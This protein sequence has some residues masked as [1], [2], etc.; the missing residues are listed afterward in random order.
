MQFLLLCDCTFQ[1]RQYSK[2]HR[3]ERQHVIVHVDTDQEDCAKLLDRYDQ[4]TL[5]VVDDDRRVLGV[6][7]VDDLIDVMQEEADEDIAHL[8]GADPIEGSY[9]KAGILSMVRMRASWLVLLFLAASL[10]TSIIAAFEEKLETM[11]LLAVF[12]PLLIGTGG[13]AGAQTTT[14]IIRAMALGDVT[15]KDALKV[16]LREARVGLLLG[17]VMALTAHALRH[18]TQDG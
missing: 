16:W 12:I 1:T 7:A 9:L 3:T 11:A 14:T 6:I 5:P 8:G 2:Q 4:I 18:P 10:T 13:N 17:L 15:Y